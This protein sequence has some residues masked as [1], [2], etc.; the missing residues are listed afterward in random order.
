MNN[1]VISGKVFGERGLRQTQSG[2]YVYSFTIG[3]SLRPKGELSFF[4][5]TAWND[6]AIHLN[7]T[8]VDK[9][10]Y[11]IEGFLTQRRWENKEGKKISS[12]EIVAIKAERLQKK[13]TQ[14]ELFLSEEKK[15][16]EDIPF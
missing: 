3:N 2:K 1:V 16:L 7:E 15:D 4:K 13:V 11:K 9:A 14:S 6:L 12:I 8:M 5:I 10:V